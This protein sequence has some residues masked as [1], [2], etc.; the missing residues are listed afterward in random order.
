MNYGLAY[1]MC[2]YLQY[3]YTCYYYALRCGGVGGGRGVAAERWGGGGDLT[4]HASICSTDTSYI[5]YSDITIQ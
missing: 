5:V 2:I 4:M 3:V 1:I